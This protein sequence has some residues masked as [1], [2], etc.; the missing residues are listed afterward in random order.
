[1]KASVKT[2]LGLVALCATIALSACGSNNDKAAN[3][4]SPSSSA[5]TSSESAPASPAAEPKTI[6]V[7][8]TASNWK[9]DIDKIEANVGDTIKVTLENKSG[10]HA[11]KFGDL[12]V[13]VKNGETK[14]IVVDK[15]GT[16]EYHCSITCGQGHDNMTGN[17][18][19][20]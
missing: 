13:E 9:L 7:T 16:F 19:V 15:A 17:L 6:E 12:G 10:M 5:P 1:M 3:S 2:L 20:S 14:E 18:I 8:I 4:N 11:I